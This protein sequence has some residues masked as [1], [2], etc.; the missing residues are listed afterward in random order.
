M[1]SYPHTNYSNE[2]FNEQASALKCYIEY[3][4]NV[5]YMQFMHRKNAIWVENKLSGKV[6]AGMYRYVDI[7]SF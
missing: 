7:I 1:K 5:E 4:T 2:F 3:F 6:W